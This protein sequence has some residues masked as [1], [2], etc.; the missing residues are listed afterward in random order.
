MLASMTLPVT[1]SISA[2]VCFLLLLLLVMRWCAAKMKPS[3]ML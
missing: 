3:W 1:A 2:A